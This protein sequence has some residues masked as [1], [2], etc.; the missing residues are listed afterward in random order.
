MRKRQLVIVILGIVFIGLM[1]WAGSILPDLLPAKPSEQTQTAQ[2][3]PYQVILSV[4]PNPPLVMHPATLTLQITRK[5]TQQA[6]GNASVVLES[7]METMDMGT[8]Q[9][10]AQEQTAG[11][12]RAQVQFSMS[13]P[14]QVRVLINIPGAVPERASFEIVA[15]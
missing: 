4:N 12:Y 3:G 5:G 9:T 1:G 11:I 15:H 7:S 2:A 6:I 8:D 10:N 13:G 14:W